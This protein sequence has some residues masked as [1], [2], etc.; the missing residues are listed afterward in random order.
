VSATE[1][2]TNA[3]TT[4]EPVND[5]GRRSLR[6]TAASWFDLG[7]AS[8]LALLT[9]FGLNLVDE[10]D[11]LAFATLTP[12]IRDAFNLSDSQIVAVGSISALFVLISSIPV[13]YLADR[14]PRLRLARLA[15]AGWGAMGV[16]A[17]VAWSVPVL[18]FAR[19]FSG[20]AK[21]SNEVVHT[22]L[23]ADYMV[24]ARNA[25]GAGTWGAGSGGLARISPACP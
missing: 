24:R 10:F 9:L 14:V 2:P 23:L 11:R 5:S 13:G 21:C 22:G 12:E 1:P 17:G 6:T 15:A 25:C 7:D 18:F 19:F 8:R 20:A 4:S 16:L 3:A